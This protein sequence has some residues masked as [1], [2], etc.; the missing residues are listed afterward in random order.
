MK[1]PPYFAGIRMPPTGIVLAA[2]QQPAGGRASAA[3]SAWGWGPERNK[4]C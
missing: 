1:V 3:S 2:K 4:E